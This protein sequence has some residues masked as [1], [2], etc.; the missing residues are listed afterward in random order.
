MSFVKTVYANITN[1]LLPKSESI[2]SQPV[3]YVN[4]VIQSIISIFIIVAIV[5]FIFQLILGGY[6]IIASNG[7]PKKYEEAMAAIRYSL[8]GIIIIFSIFAIIKLLGGIFG[9]TSLTN[10]SIP[11]P[12]L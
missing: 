12:S 6:K 8:T 1:P 5:Y 10:L 11:W 9:I 4:S 7:D 2:A 3:P